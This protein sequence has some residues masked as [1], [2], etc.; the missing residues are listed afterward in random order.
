[1][2]IKSITL[3]TIC[4]FL[5]ILGAD[6][7][8]IS[9]TLELDYNGDGMADENVTQMMPE[10]SSALDLLQN[11]SE[12]TTEEA[13]WG[14]FVVGI[15]GTMADWAKEQSWWM[16]DV[17]GMQADIGV[18]KYMLN[19]GDTV[20]MSFM[21]GNPDA[22]SVLLTLDYNG[23]G[24]IDKAPHY[25]MA[26]DSTALDLLSES[27]ELTTEET[28]WGILVV[29]IDG[30]MA[31]WTAEHSWW[32]FKVNGEQAN[33]TVDKYMLEN[34]DI[35]SMS[36][37]GAE[38]E[39]ITVVLEQDNNGDG[40][41]DSATHYEI[42]EGSTALDLLRKAA[43]QVTTQNLDFGTTVVGIDGVMTNW[44]I[45]QSWW[46]FAVDGEMSN[47]TV[48]KFMLEN[49]QTVTMSLAGAEEGAKHEA[50]TT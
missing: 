25:E 47:V 9:A 11:A 15:D 18:D 37:V 33:V 7:M 23:D 39:M 19:D 45:D 13:G 26:K 32:M 30:T 28:E 41:I 6:A 1:M 49:G 10:G 29:E 4:L 35:V 12:L 44:T 46:Q 31:N 38:P 8:D 21:G 36:F 14:I 50:E 16:F 48:D 24:V 40:V 17:N 34:G 27:S 3:A 20:S 42:A 2:K 22:I 5:L 43:D